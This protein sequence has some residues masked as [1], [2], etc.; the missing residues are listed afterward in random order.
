LNPAKKGMFKGRDL[1]SLRAEAEKLRAKEKRT[2]AEST[3]LKELNF[4]IRAKKSWPKG[5]GAAK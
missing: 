4:A 3:K 5:K 1:A 2:A